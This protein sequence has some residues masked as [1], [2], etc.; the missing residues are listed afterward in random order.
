MTPDQPGGADLLTA[1]A[2]R[3]RD[4]VMRHVPDHHRLS[5][6]MILSA[7]GM[8]E[9]ELLSGGEPVGEWTAALQQLLGDTAAGTPPTEVMAR[10]ARHI[11]AGDF[12]EGSEAEH[13]HA[14]LSADVRHRLAIANPK[15]LE[16]AEK[17]G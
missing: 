1:A 8:A 12:D 15:Y 7:M 4:E 9:R 17:T 6:L 3:L 16:S 11:R 2:A 13:L 5:V 10:L 14:A